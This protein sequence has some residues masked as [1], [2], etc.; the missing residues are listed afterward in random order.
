VYFHKPKKP[1]AILLKLSA[2][3]QPALSNDQFLEIRAS[4]LDANHPEKLNQN[5]S[6]DLC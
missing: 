4:Y 2:R 1:A 3:S 6:I 5:G